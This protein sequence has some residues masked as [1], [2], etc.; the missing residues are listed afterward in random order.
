MAGLDSLLLL[1][2]MGLSSDFFQIIQDTVLKPDFVS[3]IAL[4]WFSLLNELI[5]LLPYVIVVSGQILFINS[6]LSIVIFS[7]LLFF[8][9]IPAGIGGALGSLFIYSLSYFGGKPT[10]NKLNK[11]LRF[12]WKDVEKVT[13][14]FNGAWY[15]E[16]LFL[17]LRSTPVLPSLPINIA[18]GIL[19]MRPIPYFALT[20]LGFIIRMMIM[21][22]II[23][24]GVETLAQ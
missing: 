17:A 15:D 7:K 4:F 21:F 2:T 23:G 24:F 10:I 9:A 19:R 8:V 14:R 3:A 13:G 16:I 11:Y 6:H 22:M 18:A 20:L 1:N 5:A 12:S